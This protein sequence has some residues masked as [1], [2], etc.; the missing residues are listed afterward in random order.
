MV[1]EDGVCCG[2]AAQVRHS[3]VYD[4]V[5]RQSHVKAHGFIDYVLL[6]L[7]LSW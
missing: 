7:V 4:I 2:K 3:L 5:S 1:A 6:R